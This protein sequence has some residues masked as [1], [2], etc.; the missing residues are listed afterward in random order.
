MARHD[1]AAER[2]RG[3]AS[4]L[5]AHR[6]ALALA[7]IAAGPPLIMHDGWSGA[8]PAAAGLVYAGHLVAGKRRPRWTRRA[9]R[10]LP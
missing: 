4:R 8:L 10:H 2:R 9:R 5:P 6:A 3:P 1:E 7:L